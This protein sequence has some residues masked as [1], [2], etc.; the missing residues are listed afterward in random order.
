[1]GKIYL[2]LSIINNVLENLEIGLEKG[3]ENA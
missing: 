3:L 2:K 1:M